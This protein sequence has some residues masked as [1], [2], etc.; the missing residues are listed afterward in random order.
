[1]AF[2]LD[3]LHEDLNR[4]YNKPYIEE[5]ESDGRPDHLVAKEAWEDYKKRN[6]SIIVDLMHGQLKSTVVCNVC[7]KISIKFDPFCFLSVPVPT[8]EKQIRSVVAVYVENKW[9]KF[10]VSHTNKTMV[11]QVTAALKKELHLT[12]PKDRLILG[13]VFALISQLLFLVTTF[14][15]TRNIIDEES[16]MPHNT[17]SVSYSAT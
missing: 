6:D 16:L 3:G 12:D 7:G 8:K 10:I 17:F 9:R 13:E 2:L 1:M 14:G 4:I 5:K 15:Q 11:K